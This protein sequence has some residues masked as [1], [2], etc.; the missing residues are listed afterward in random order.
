MKKQRMIQ[1]IFLFVI[2][3]ISLF[4]NFSLAGGG[5]ITEGL[6]GSSR[7]ESTEGLDPIE[8]PGSF[9]PGSLPEEDINKITKYDPESTGD[10]KAFEEGSINGFGNKIIYTKNANNVGYN[11][12]MM[13]NV[14]GTYGNSDT[15]FRYY[16]EVE[17][18]W[19]TL[20]ERESIE[21]TSTEYYYYPDTLKTTSDGEIKGISTNSPEYEMLFL[22]SSDGQDYW[23]A[24]RMTHGNLGFTRLGFRCVESG[25]VYRYNVINSNGGVTTKHYG[26]RPVVSLESDISIT[27]G[28]GTSV[29]T[30][31]QIQ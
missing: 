18:I 19:K 20:K 1:F 11:A 24:T 31:H 14:I 21:V 3:I 15:I 4:P 6:G 5:G 26:V 13:N 8:N 25:I 28:E 29:S 23:L 10:G 2:I 22:R 7:V 30:A 17:K 16:D 12:I 9:Q 27:E